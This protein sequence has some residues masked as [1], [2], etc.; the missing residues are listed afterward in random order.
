MTWFRGKDRALFEA[1]SRWRR[2]KKS[3]RSQ[4]R[5]TAV[6]NKKDQSRGLEKDISASKKEQPVFKTG[7]KGFEG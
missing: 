5:H 6:E 3:R 7:L 2:R 1:S 4:K